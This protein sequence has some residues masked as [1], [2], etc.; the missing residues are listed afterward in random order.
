[1]PHTS[2]RPVPM[3]D[4][5]RHRHG[6][7]SKLDPGPTRHWL[8]SEYSLEKEMFKL[9]L[10]AHNTKAGELR[11]RIPQQL[12]YYLQRQQE[13]K[14]PKGPFN[15]VWLLCCSWGLPGAGAKGGRVSFGSLF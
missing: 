6:L 2:S 9:N 10:K 8:V 11:F 4:P 14:D 12:T 13:S 1:M 5:V 7:V 3:L 15:D